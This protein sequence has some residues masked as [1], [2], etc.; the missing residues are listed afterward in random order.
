MYFTYVM[1][2]NYLTQ[3]LNYLAPLKVD[4]VRVGKNMDGGYVLGKNELN[5]IEYLISLGMGGERNN[6]SFE[7]E[8]LKINKNIKITFYDHTV[9][10]K[11]YLINIFRIFRRLIKLRYKIKDLTEMFNHFFSYII[12]LNSGRIFHKKKKILRNPQKKNEKNIYEIFKNITFNNVLLKVD[13]EGFEYEII[14][15]IINSSDKI[16][17]LIIEFHEIDKHEDIFENKIKL[18]Q[19]EFEIIHI[20][21]NNNTG[22][23]R[24]NLP[25]TLEITFINKKNCRDH[26]K[27][28]RYDFPVKD[29]DFP[30]NPNFDDIYFS[31]KEN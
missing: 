18:L 7:E 12:L 23:Q 2:K 16:L 17:S 31:F 10:S 20:H 1:N 13:I 8:F 26:N 3:K 22:I 6:W 25:K 28:F 11:N 15:Q 19:S 14:D 5:K 30:N 9:S 4:L 21:G 27:E 29:I 24:V